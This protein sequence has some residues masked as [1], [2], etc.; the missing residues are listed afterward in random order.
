MIALCCGLL[1]NLEG[2]AGSA[3]KIIVP[4]FALAIPILA[5]TLVSPNTGLIATG[6]VGF[7]IALKD[8][9]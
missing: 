8:V 5:I 1:S 9:I 3:V 4:V 7:S 6:I 2:D